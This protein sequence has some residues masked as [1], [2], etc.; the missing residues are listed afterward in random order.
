MVYGYETRTLNE[1]GLKEMR[2]VTFSTRPDTLRAIAQFLVEAAAQLESQPMS[3]NW[4]R[5]V[6]P[7]IARSLC[8]DV[9][10]I[11]MP[12]DETSRGAADEREWIT[13]D[14]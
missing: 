14:G 2:E 12:R 5:H 13:G 9:I 6:S 10:V 8:C 3:P 4:H 11:E 7:A 1:Y